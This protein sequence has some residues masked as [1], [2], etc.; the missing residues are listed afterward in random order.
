MISSTPRQR[1]RRQAIAIVLAALTRS[2]DRRHDISLMRGVFEQTLRQ[3]VPV[4]TV[5]LREAGSRWTSRPEVCWR[6]ID[7]PRSARRRSLARL[8]RGHVRSG[9]PAG[10]VGLSDARHRRACGR[11]GPRNR[12]VP[13]AAGA[14]RAARSTPDAPRRRRAAHR[15]DAGD[16]GAAVEHRARGGHRFHGAARGRERRRQGARRASDPRAEPP[17]QLAR[18]S[19]STAPRSSKR[20]SRPSCSASRSAPPPVSAAGAASS[21][22]PTAA[23]CSSTKCRTCR[24]RRRPSCCARFRISRSSASAATARTASTSGSSPPPTAASRHWSSGGCFGPICST[25]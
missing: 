10:R 5:T 1:D 7:R 23:R 19:P 22:T 25:A 15:I 12:A 14:R 6:R 24:C 16:A 3:V 18:S 2:L 4:R 21:S 11:A 13:D 9:L 17:P 20:C 8:A